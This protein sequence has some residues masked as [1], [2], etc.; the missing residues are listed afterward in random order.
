M[1]GE[2]AEGNLKGMGDNVGLEGDAARRSY[3]GGSDGMVGN[4]KRG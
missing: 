2:R 4:S 1:K 3:A